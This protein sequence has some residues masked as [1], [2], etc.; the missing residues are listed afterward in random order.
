MDFLSDVNGFYNTIGNND[1]QFQA[2]M[3]FAQTIAAELDSN[4]FLADMQNKLDTFFLN[5]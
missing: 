4:S 2:S 5:R 1:G 3:N